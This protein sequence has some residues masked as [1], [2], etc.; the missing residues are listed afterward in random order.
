MKT[1]IKK[2]MFFF[3]ICLFAFTF[4]SCGGVKFAAQTERKQ[5]FQN[6]TISVYPVHI[7]TANSDFN[8]NIS[9]L[10]VDYLNKKENLKAVL[11]Y[12]TPPVNSQWYMNE[13]KMFSKSVNSFIPYIK[14]NDKTGDFCLLV[15]FLKQPREICVHYYLID[16]ATGKAVCAGLCNSDHKEHRLINPKTDEDAFTLFKVLFD[17]NIEEI[18]NN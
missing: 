1:I 7:L 11:V 9:T 8:T 15:E 2:S 12:Q 18:K 6:K 17:K 10:I 14:T 3:E 16:K 5:L 4:Y 13:A